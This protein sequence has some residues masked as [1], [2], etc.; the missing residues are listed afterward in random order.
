MLRIVHN[1]VFARIFTTDGLRIA[2]AV[3]GALPLLAEG[4]TT[5]SFD[6]SK[7][8]EPAVEQLICKDPELAARDRQLADAYAAAGGKATAAEKDALASAER[9]WINRRNDCWKAAD[10]AACVTNAYRLRLAEVQ[11]T[12]RLIE[13]IGTGRYLCTSTPPHEVVADFFATDPATA[14]VSLDGVRQFMFVAPSGSGARYT[15]GDR[16]FWEH[17]G[18]ARV[19]WGVRSYELNCPKQT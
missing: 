12:F 11:A 8:R 17:Q 4:Q 14:M 13:P 18:V 19:N 5:P 3:L 15:G 7:P 16:Q 6:C 10:A 2:L 1:I 9:A